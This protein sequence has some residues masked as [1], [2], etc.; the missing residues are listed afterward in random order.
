MGLA[1]EE[2][3][4]VVPVTRASAERA[5]REWRARWKASPLDL[6]VGWALGRACFDWAEFAS[7]DRDRAALAEEGIDACRRILE[8][9]TNHWVGAY[10]LGLN[11]GQLARTKSF[12]A[13]RLV[14]EMEGRFKQVLEAE[15]GLDHG[16][17]SRYLAQLYQQAPGWPTSVGNRHK[18]RVQ[19][20]KAVDLAPFYPENALLQMEAFRE[21]GDR[22][23]LIKAAKLYEGR[24]AECR[25]RFSPEVWVEEWKEWSQRWDRL[26]SAAGFSAR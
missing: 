3:P 17:P 7:G 25:A 13:L 20:Q 21:W 6:E 24:L 4:G 14:S 19:F 5:Y 16:G 23:A 2:R 10:Y 26:R 1:A 18:A 12:G 11:L 22:A 8:H 9:Q 15:P